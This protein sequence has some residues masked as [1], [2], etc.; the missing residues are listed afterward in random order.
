VLANQ[1]RVT[2]NS[3]DEKTF[4]ATSFVV[5]ATRGL[6]RDQ[7]TRRQSMLITLILALGFLFSG[8]TFLQPALNPHEHPGR[9]VLFWVICAWLTFTAILLAI[10]DLLATRVEAR[11]AARKLREELRPD[12]PSSRSE[13]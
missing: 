8:F 10:F 2:N 13:Q 3:S 4:R 5:H 7:K 6:I 1:I 9:F 11:R 12:F